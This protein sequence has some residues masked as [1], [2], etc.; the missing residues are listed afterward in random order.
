MTLSICRRALSALAPALLI[1]G[2]LQAVAHAQSTP[3]SASPLPLQQL[4]RSAQKEGKVSSVGMPDSWANW[5]ATWD[6]LQRLY[7]IQHV[8]TDMSS[9]EEIAKMIA[10]GKNARV[11]IGDIGYEFAELAKSRGITA[12]YKPST[13]S[14][15]PSWARDTDGHW[16]IAYTGTIAFAVN[17]HRLK[18]TLH[19]WK[20]VLASDARV[21]IGE[22]GR[23]AQANAGVLSLAIA[24][25]GDESHL[26]PALDAFA[27]LA[28]Q[29]RV[30]MVNPSPAL[31]ERGEADVFVLWDFNG[32]TYR[33]TLPNKDDYDIV[34]PS[35]GSVTSGYTTIINRYAP[36]PAAARL[37][38][39]YIFSDAG[40]LNLA[41]GYARPIR[42]DHLKLPADVSARLIDSK[43]YA[44][45]RPVRISEWMAAVTT[46]G[47]RWQT[48]VA[49]NA[50]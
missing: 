27:R 33:S 34:I 5:K 43:Q 16:M 48:G 49:A 13:W 44:A 30:L 15:L 24:L 39:E 12:P 25:G 35:D 11:D 45:A 14:Q 10:E 8:D 7:G 32:L 40:Q 4:Q 21:C 23:A 31:M 41:R 1:A 3:G 29:G 18:K 37:T 22:V 9:A 47:A 46:L 17:R 28:K 38:R 50:P 36:H 2:A 26:N 6:D 42:I 19:S 20:D